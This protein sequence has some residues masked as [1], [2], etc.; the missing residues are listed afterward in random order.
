MSAEGGQTG[1]SAEAPV[2]VIELVAE[3]A[4]GAAAFDAVRRVARS[5]I[6]FRS[7][8][9]QMLADIGMDGIRAVA[10]KQIFEALNDRMKTQIVGDDDGPLISLYGAGIVI[11]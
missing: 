5:V 4:E 3:V 9:R 10:L 7:P 11:K 8:V 6:G 2:Q 1:P